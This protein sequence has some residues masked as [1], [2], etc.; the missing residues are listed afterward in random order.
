VDVVLGRDYARGML[1]QAVLNP[2]VTEVYDHLLGF[3][4]E[5][6]DLYAVPVPERM[7]GR[8]FAEASLELVDDDRETVTVLGLDRS[9]EGRPRSRFT[10]CPAAPGSTLAAPDLILQAG[11]RLVVMAYCRPTVPGS[12]PVDRWAA[13][14]LERR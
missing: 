14:W 5:S 13:T 6:N 4:D 1:A 7:V 11:D 9:P 12:E 3:S 8:T 10:L 2:G